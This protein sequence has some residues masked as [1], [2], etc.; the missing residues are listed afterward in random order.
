MADYIIT[1]GDDRSIEI[2]VTDDGTSTGTAVDVS[3]ATISW[4]AWRQGTDTNAIDKTL[5]D[6]EVTVSGAGNN[7]ITLDLTDTITAALVDDATYNNHVQV[8]IGTETETID[9]FTFKAVED[10][11]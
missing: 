8:T 6:A 3:A 7:V 2:T 10:A 1:K 11:P 4:K 5:A 9:K